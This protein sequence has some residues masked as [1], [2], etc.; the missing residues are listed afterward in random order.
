MLLALGSATGS[1]LTGQPLSPATCRGRFFDVHG[2]PLAV[3]RHP[4]ELLADPALK[5]ETWDDLQAIALRLNTP[6]AQP[7]A[8]S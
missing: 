1:L 6:G 8:H 2:V 7:S 5:R 4:A 3:I